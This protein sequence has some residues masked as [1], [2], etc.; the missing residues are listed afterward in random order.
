MIRCIFGVVVA[1]AWS[2][3]GHALDAGD[4]CTLKATLPVVIQS[5]GANVPTTFDVETEVRV[6]YVD[7]SG[8]SRVT[9]GAVRGVVVTRELEAACAGTLRLC[10]AKGAFSV[11]ERN[12][13]DSRSW[14]VPVGAAFSVLRAGK[15]WAHL[16]VDQQEGFA[17]APE[18]EAR[19]GAEGDG[20]SSQA[21][22]ERPSEDA[23]ATP[24][25][26]VDRGDGP[27]ILVLPFLLDDGA[28]AAAAD[29]L[30]ARFDERLRIYR[31][32]VGHLPLLGSRTA[33]WKDHVDGAVKRARAAG[34]AYALVGRVGPDGGTGGVGGAKA[35]GAFVVMIAVVD[36]SNGKTVKGVRARPMAVDDDGWI[37]PALAGLLAAVPAAP[38]GRQ[39]SVRP[40][41]STSTTATPTATA[42]SSPPTPTTGESWGTPW[43]ANPWGYLTLAVSVGTGVGAGYL[44]QGALDANAA[45]NATPLLDERRGER[46]AAALQQAVTADALAATSAVAGVATVVIFAARVG[47]GE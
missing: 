26:V 23:N 41:S 37:D 45:A 3:A 20:A 32:D 17:P 16:M 44:G 10:R 22:S 34:L 28:P 15:V 11:F 14:S 21:P 12:R 18:V 30:A 31:P 5:S 38:E 36:A 6:L 24:V 9:N 7:V 4:A 47:I 33:P 46:R 1:L 42:T 25:E 8:R 43:F 40:P 35:G 2:G 13:S 19:C 27:G 39:P 29:K